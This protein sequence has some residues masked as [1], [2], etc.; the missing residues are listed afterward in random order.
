MTSS[1]EKPFWQTTALAQMSRE[2]W[3]SLCDGCG[4]C[5]LHKLEDE[6]SGDVFYT[7]VA[8]RYLSVE[9]RCECYAQR[10]EKVAAC[11]TLRPQDLASVN[12]LPSTCAYRLIAEGK[13]LPSWHP[14][15]SGDRNSVHAA[16]QSV[17]GRC[18]KE[19]DIAEEDYE[20]RIVFWPE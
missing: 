3:E 5:C 11:M 6:D 18:V 19:S 17:K 15:V 7:D 2:Q 13:H 9:C 12:W 1:K 10:S 20:D 4:K 16:S 14:L 8:C